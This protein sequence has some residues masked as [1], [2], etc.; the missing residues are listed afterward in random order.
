MLAGGRSLSVRKFCCLHGGVLIRWQTGGRSRQS[1]ENKQ[2]G[3]TAGEAARIILDI[4]P[5]LNLNSFGPLRRL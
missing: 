5:A 3:V 2:D 4:N 1:H